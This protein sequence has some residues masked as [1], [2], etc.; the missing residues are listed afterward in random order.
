MK[1]RIDPG[2]QFKEVLDA[3]LQ[4][5]LRPLVRLMLKMGVPFPY[6]AR[7]MKHAYLHVIQE[8]FALPNRKLSRSRMALLSGLSRPDVQTLLGEPTEA[9]LDPFLW[10]RR[11]RVL[12]GWIKDPDFQDKGGKPLVLPKEGEK[13]FKSLCQ[14]YGTDVPYRAILDN[15]M[16]EGLVAYNEEG[17]LE[18]QSPV[19]ERFEHGLKQLQEQS[20]CKC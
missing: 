18:L 8:E 15:A 20:C 10:N 16:E 2:K 3:C 19:V 14:R 7:Q 6:V 9:D 13:S 4:D 5:V 11:V 1:E 12:R 17:L